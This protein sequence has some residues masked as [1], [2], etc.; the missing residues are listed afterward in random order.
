MP[1]FYVVSTQSHGCPIKGI[2]F[3]LFVISHFP[4]R[5]RFQNGLNF[6]KTKKICIENVA[7]NVCNVSY[8]FPNLGKVL[9]TLKRSSQNT[10]LI[11]VLVIDMIN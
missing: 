2:Q 3:D 5:M 4:I 9:H 1:I 10:F 6:K 11:L 7:E 8:C